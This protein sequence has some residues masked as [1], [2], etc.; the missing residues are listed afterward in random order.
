MVPLGTV[1]G[2]VTQTV[3]EL[4][5]LRCAQSVKFVQPLVDLQLNSAQAVIQPLENLSVSQPEPVQVENTAT[6]ELAQPVA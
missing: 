5:S 4:P 1:V 3:A 6:A 2:Q